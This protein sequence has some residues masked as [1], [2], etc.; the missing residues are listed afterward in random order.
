MGSLERHVRGWSG[1]IAR[2]QAGPTAEQYEQAAEAANRLANAAHAIG[3]AV[4]ENVLSGPERQAFLRLVAQLESQARGL[5]NSAT[6]RDGA[7]ME[8]SFTRLRTT[9]NECHARFRDVAG[10]L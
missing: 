7:G 10:T 3:E 9:C 1:E 6:A 5:A 2:L 8:A 4:P